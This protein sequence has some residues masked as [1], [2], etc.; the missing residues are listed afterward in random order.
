MRL[1]YVI[2]YVPNVGEATKFYEAAFGMTCRMHQA[3]GDME[4]AELSTGDTVLAFASE[5]LA[6]SHGFSY[7]RVRPSEDAPA[8]EIALVTDDVQAAYDKAVSC[9]ATPLHQPVD[10]PWGQTISYVRD[11][12][13]FLIEICSPVLAS[14]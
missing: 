12:N 6:D 8:M 2:L 11:K 13:G 10:K 4:Y 5:P 9:G 7:K 14:E 1:G 3:E